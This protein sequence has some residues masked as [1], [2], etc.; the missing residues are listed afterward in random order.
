VVDKHEK[1]RRRES[2]SVRDSGEAASAQH[3]SQK[4]SLQDLNSR[5][6]VK[7]RRSKQRETDAYFECKTID[8]NKSTT[9]TPR[10]G[11]EM[12]EKER[13]GIVN[14]S[15]LPLSVHNL[16]HNESVRPVIKTQNILLIARR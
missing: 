11:E 4:S 10:D 2:E 3:R 15:S 5:E 6:E 12:N 7:R 9:A 13:F 14:T 1:K 16:K 8:A